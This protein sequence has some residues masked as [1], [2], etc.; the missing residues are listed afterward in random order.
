MRAALLLACALLPLGG[1]G[2]KPLYAGGGSGAAASALAAIEVAPVQGRSGWLLVNALRDRL[3]A[4]GAPRYRLDLRLDDRIS[5]LGVR[6]DDSIARE[7]RTLRARWQLVEV[8]TG[9]VVIDTTAGSDAGIDVVGSEYA[10]IAAEN[11]A[12]ERLAGIVADQ[13]VGRIA[14]HARAKSTP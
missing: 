4:Q 3:P 5:G 14:L 9:A 10:T 8:G 1:C 12:L 11:T 6:R 2:L 7:R 13:I